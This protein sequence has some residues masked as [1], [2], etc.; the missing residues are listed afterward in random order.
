MV[1]LWLFIVLVV[2]AVAAVIAVL[3]IDRRSGTGPKRFQP[4]WRRRG[5]EQVGEPPRRLAN[6]AS[7]FQ[8]PAVRQ[9]IRAQRWLHALLAVMLVSALLSA[10]AI[11]GRPVRVSQRSDALANRDIV[12][13]LDVSTS[14][15]RIDSSVLTTF[16]EI[17]EDF[18]GE[19]VGLVAWNS[20]AQTIVPLT[21]DYELLREQLQELG[22]VLDI[23]PKNV[24]LKQQRD[25][26]RAFGG[27]LTTGVNGSSLA[28][29]GLASCAQAFDNQGLDRS[30][31]IILATD[32]QV[33]DPDKEQIYP[34][35]DAVKLLN[36]RKIRLFSIYGADDEQDYQNLLDKTPEESREELK[37][38]TEGQGKGRFYDV[39]DSGTGGEIVKE[40]EKTE[41]SAL[42]GRK[43]TRRT[44]TPQRLVITLSL[45]LLGYLGLTTWRRA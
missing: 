31:S 16:S 30:R 13:C 36:E 12:L 17:L 4:P 32:N 45:V 39:E 35:P 26:E 21:D 15:V 25:Y 11:A 7:L 34:L 20:A 37:T 42:G 43:Q 5:A 19:R 1:M 3:V 23:N 41:V 8:L 24:T 40:L 29:D 22:D 10:A 38:V 2:I 9:R 28:G 33:I 18:D 44:D 14:M 27:T 6:S